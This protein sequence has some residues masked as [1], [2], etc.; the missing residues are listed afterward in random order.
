MQLAGI[1]SAPPEK[2]RQKGGAAA[3]EMNPSK[4]K[5]YDEADGGD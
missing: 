3:A 2:N 4:P 1:V 5:K